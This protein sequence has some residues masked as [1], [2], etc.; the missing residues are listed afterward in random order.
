MNTEN[1]TMG[2]YVKTPK[3][4]TAEDVSMFFHSRGM[5]GMNRG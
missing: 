2:N 1:Q 4:E 5:R 3:L